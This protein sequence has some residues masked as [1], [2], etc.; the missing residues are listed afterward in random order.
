MYT[1]ELYA[2]A[3]QLAESMGYQVREEN[4]GGI[5]GGVCEV[6]GRKCVFVDIAMNSVEQFE[7][8]I[9]ALSQDPMIHT[10]ALPPAL[11]QHLQAPRRAA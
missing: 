8:L 3:K 1:V 11:S 7:Q 4:L 10:T 5:G 6:A 9:S 2:T